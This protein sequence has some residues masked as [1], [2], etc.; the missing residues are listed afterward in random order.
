MVEIFQMDESCV[1]KL[2][3][4]IVKVARV[5]RAASRRKDAEKRRGANE[6]VDNQMKLYAVSLS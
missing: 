2:M 6:C 1:N 3:M 4:M 5:M